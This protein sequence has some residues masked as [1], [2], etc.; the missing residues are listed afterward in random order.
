MMR[1][2]E[3]QGERIHER[4]CDLLPWYVN[5]S[6]AERERER[7]EAHLAVCARCQEE[8]GICRRTAEAVKSA[9]EVA[10][11]PHPVQFQRMLARIEESEREQ[12]A[13]AAWWKRG[14]PFRSL[15]EATP[16]PLRGAL[17]AQAAIVILLIGVLAWRELH[18]PAA[19]TP[20]APP[21]VYRT[22]ADPAPAP[23][24]SIGLHLMFAPQTSEREI[25]AL[26]LG[27]RGQ[28][29]AGPSPLGV[30]TVEIPAGGDPANVVLA[31]LRSESQVTFAEPVAGGEPEK[32]LDGQ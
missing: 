17:V 11:S 2:L 26:L 24:P 13:R 14:E 6:L 23:Q 10:P 18:V 16:A 7:V 1:K 32:K 22:L 27:V 8:E 15:V 3:D 5:G 25:R 31:R 19:G 20:A 9:G 28:I 12:R 29:T 21:A 4:I 30:Y